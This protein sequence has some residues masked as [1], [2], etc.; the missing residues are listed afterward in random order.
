MLLLKVSQLNLNSQKPQWDYT[1][2]DVVC[3]ENEAYGGVASGYKVIRE[4]VLSLQEMSDSSSVCVSHP[5]RHT[6]G[7]IQ[8]HM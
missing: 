2:N 7:P 1:K 5:T 3:N 4:V 6:N 8:P